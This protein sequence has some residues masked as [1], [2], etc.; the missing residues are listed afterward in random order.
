MSN[1]QSNGS[2]FMERPPES[3]PKMEARLNVLGKARD[4]FSNNL[5]RTKEKKLKDKLLLTGLAATGA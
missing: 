2:K 5:S 3:Q 1:L 4:K